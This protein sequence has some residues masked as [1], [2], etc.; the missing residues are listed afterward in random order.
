MTT[1]TNTYLSKEESQSD[2]IPLVLGVIMLSLLVGIFFSY[3]LPTLRADSIAKQSGTVTMQKD[4][5]PTITAALD[6][7]VTA[8]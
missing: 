1:I 3:T 8:P 6:S 2:G 7:G 4:S 5:R